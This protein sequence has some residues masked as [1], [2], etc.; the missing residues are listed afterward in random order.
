M[1]KNAFLSR[2]FQEKVSY[3]TTR[4]DIISFAKLEVTYKTYNWNIRDGKAL[5]N[6]NYMIYII[7]VH[8][9]F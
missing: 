8:I 6:A 4:L 5:L 9:I 7:T 1:V 2:V 3:V